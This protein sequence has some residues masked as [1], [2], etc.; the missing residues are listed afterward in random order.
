[1]DVA[2]PGDRAPAVALPKPKQTHWRH[3]DQVC[4]VVTAGDHKGPLHPTP[5][6]S[7]LQISRFILIYCLH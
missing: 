1:M 3:N 4:A 7:P 2:S 6:R 5:P